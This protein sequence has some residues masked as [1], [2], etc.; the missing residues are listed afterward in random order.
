MMLGRSIGFFFGGVLSIVCSLEL[1]KHV[2]LNHRYAQ[3]NNTRPKFRPLC[4]AFSF[5]LLMHNHFPLLLSPRNKI[6]ICCVCVDLPE[7]GTSF[8]SY[9]VRDED[10]DEDRPRLRRHGCW[11][12]NTTQESSSQ[13][14]SIIKICVKLLKKSIFHISQLNLRLFNLSTYILGIYWF[15]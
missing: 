10:E 11:W 7:K 3:N 2:H 9:L 5:L 6:Y 12:E 1:E 14:S 15:N 13:H 8:L 4:I